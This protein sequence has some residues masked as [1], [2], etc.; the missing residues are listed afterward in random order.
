M[1]RKTPAVGIL[2]LLFLLACNLA[3]NLPTG[4]D[5]GIQEGT[6]VALANTQLAQ[7][8]M[9]LDLQLTMTA[10][11]RSVPQS[12]NTPLPTNTPRSSATQ[13]VVTV[14]V[15]VETNCRT[16]PGNPYPI[17]DVLAV[18]QT[19]EVIGRNASSDTWI[20][21]LPSNP[22][23]TCWLWGQYATVSGNGAALPVY[24]SPPTPIPVGGSTAS[25]T[26][27][28]NSSQAVFYLY[29]SPTT[30][31]SWGDDQ[32]GA[33]T[34]PAGSSYTFTGLTPGSYDLKA[35]DSGHNIIQTWMGVSLTGSV[36]WTLPS[37]GGGGSTASL[38]VVNNSGQAIWYLYISPTT[39]S[40]WG[41][42]Q[43]GVNTIPAGSSYTFTGLTPGS[44]DLKAEDSAHNALKTWMGVSLTGSTTWTIT[45]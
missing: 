37:S 28:N 15:S 12:T 39:N 27:V 41:D 4:S 2:L 38:T 29:I 33:S 13:S 1:P 32:L 18:G 43:L 24:P 25:L 44:Y 8:R 20:I 21:R 9:S 6:A 30:N 5:D 35:E 22:S 26:V 23:V 34:I 7:T 42:D 19:A 36:T 3:S 17:V 11:A 10:M 31:S 45:P 40:S 16:G 14:R